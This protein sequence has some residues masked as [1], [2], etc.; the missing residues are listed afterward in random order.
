MSGKFQI[1]FN[2]V[3]IGCFKRFFA[4]FNHFR[5]TFCRTTLNMDYA[6]S[7]LMKRIQEEQNLWTFLDPFEARVW[8]SILFCMFMVSLLLYVL[9]RISPKRM[10]GPRFH[11][12]S[13]HGTCWFVYSSLVQQS[14][15][16]YLV[17]ASAQIVTGVWWFFILIVVSSYTAKL[18]S[19]LTIKNLDKPFESFAE[20]SR[21]NLF[22]YGTVVDTSVYKYIEKRATSDV[23]WGRMYDIIKTDAN[24]INTE[25]V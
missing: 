18:A 24:K 5:G 7:V 9:N 19:F 2:Q 21:Q 23:Q 22:Q 3:K 1:I 6:V 16:L 10:K 20:L 15:D 8:I 25:R 17:T 14:T 4:I 11:D 12:T 13:L